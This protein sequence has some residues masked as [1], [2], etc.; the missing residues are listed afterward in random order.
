MDLDKVI[1]KRKQVTKYSSKKPKIEKIVEIIQSA[2]KAF[3]HGNLHIIKYLIVEN[4]ELIAK[5]AEACQQE[6][7][8]KVPYVVVLCSDPKQIDKIF[9]VR[10]KKYIKHHV[11]AAAENFLLKTYDLG[12]SG[13]WIGA[14]SDVT[15][16][17]VL[18]IP[19]D[20]E[21]EMLITVGDG[22]KTSKKSKIPSLTTRLFFDTYWNS[23]HKGIKKV[24][25][26]DM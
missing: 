14:F 11:G 15:L 6:F 21:I 18:E 13:N 17:N 7:I 23:F 2:N 25:L 9:D 4:P 5:I 8:K 22:L 1:N 16:R 24:R 3:T 20:V 12:L 10:A 19:E 26:E